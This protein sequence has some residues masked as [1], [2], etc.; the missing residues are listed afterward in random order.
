VIDDK[1]RV[2]CPGFSMGSQQRDASQAGFTIIELIVLVVVMG[3]LS[4]TILPR[5]R[6]ET[7]F[8][9]R[10]FR[11]QIVAGLRYAQK[12]AIAARLT[13]CATFSISPAQVSFRVSSV[14]G[15]SDCTTGSVLSGVDGQPLIVA[16]TGGATFSAAPASVIFDAAGRP[17][18]AASISISGLP[19]ALAIVVE[20]ETGYV[21]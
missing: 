9:S 20:A 10:G 21:H 3:I 13:A 6:G 2:Y 15:A 4:A 7:G 12:S 1:A 17:A 19:A 18:S 8:E 16:A 14:N 5:W 11:D